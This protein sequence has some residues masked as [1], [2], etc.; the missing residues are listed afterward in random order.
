MNT[1]NATIK[2]HAFIESEFENEVNYFLSHV[3][4]VYLMQK[5]YYA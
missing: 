4:F 5:I 1:E 3:T 2:I